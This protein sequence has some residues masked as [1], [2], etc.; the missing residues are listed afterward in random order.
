M[1]VRVRV[2]IRYGENYVVTSA[3]VN[4]GYEADEPE[5]H[6]PLALAK[7]LTLPLENI[8]SERYSVVGTVV[9]AY[10][11]GYVEVCVETEDRVS[12]WVKAKAVSV[13][14][15]YEVLLSDALTE[16]LGVEIIKPKQGL[17]KFAN[18]DKVRPSEKPKYWIK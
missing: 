4:S 8:E 16:A 9:S 17:W 2:K 6:I 3:L 18:E 5:I 13:P 14:G 15:E 10:I 12:N 11:L 7:K 1:G